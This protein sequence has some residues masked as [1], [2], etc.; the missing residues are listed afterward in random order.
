MA[1]RMAMPK[2][3]TKTMLDNGYSPRMARKALASCI[4]FE[5]L[6]SG[7]RASGF[8]AF[9]VWN[10]ILSEGYAGSL[11]GKQTSCLQRYL[12]ARQHMIFMCHLLKNLNFYIGFPSEVQTCAMF[13][14]FDPSAF[15]S[16]F[17]QPRRISTRALT[18]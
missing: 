9:M 11:T 5:V 12:I 3:Y 14:C 17:S 2:A 15:H 10:L 6:L 1:W 4:D 18:W 7:F 8:Q 16:L 13:H